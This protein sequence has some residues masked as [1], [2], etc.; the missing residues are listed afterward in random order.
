MQWRFFLSQALLN[1][2]VVDVIAILSRRMCVLIIFFF[3]VGRLFPFLSILC[4][5]QH[6][7]NY[8]VMYF[9]W[10]KKNHQ[11]Q[12]LKILQVTTSPS[13]DVQVQEFFLWADYFPY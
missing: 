6:I 3:F 1:L 12:I 10:D 2:V 13:G 8:M 11:K 7:S 4:Q 9:R 5:L